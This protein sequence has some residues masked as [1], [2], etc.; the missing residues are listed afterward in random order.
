[1]LSMRTH[2]FY[3]LQ[4]NDCAEKTVEED[5]TMQ[6]RKHNTVGEGIK[7]PAIKIQNEQMREGRILKQRH[8]YP[9]SNSA[10]NSSKPIINEN[11]NVFNILV[12]DLVNKEGNDYDEE[13]HKMIQEKKINQLKKEQQIEKLHN[14]HN[15]EKTSVNMLEAL[16][17]SLNNDYVRLQAKSNKEIIVLKYDITVKNNTLREKE[18]T[19]YQNGEKL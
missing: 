2:S 5:I 10:L 13:L 8:S 3:P 7:T 19:I 17:M 16:L 11:A 6:N 14:M 12:E 4:D 15:V 9:A 1:M 18:E